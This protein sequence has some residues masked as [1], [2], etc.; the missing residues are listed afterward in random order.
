MKVIGIEIDKSKVI[1]YA[2]E[3]DGG[4][5]INLTGDFKSLALKNDTD[6]VEVINFKE[7]VHTFFDDINPDMI[8]IVARQTKGRF[9]SSTISFKL[10]GLLQIYDKIGIEFVSPQKLTAY[11]KNH[12]FPIAV[13]HSY[14]E[15]AAKLAYY[16]LNR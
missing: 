7:T 8:A 1:F 15:N 5:I 12:P 10:E 13:Q 16:L 4:E 14:Q 6:N 3:V 2:I 11:Y 9:K